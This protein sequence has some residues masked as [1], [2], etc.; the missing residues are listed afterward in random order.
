MDEQMLP[1]C[2]TVNPGIFGGKLIS[3]GRLF[4]RI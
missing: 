3:P 1:E 4:S 2:I